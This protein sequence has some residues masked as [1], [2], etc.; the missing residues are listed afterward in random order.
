MPIDIGQPRKVST[1]YTG[2]IGAPPAPTAA[3][4]ASGAA[5]AGSAKQ[6]RDL[7]S[8]E[9]RAGQ[10]RR[11]FGR[12]ASPTFTPPSGAMPSGGGGTGVATTEVE[13]EA[14]WM[15]KWLG[16]AVAAA[17]VLSQTRKKRR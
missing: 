2:R 16:A 4:S 9:S 17:L 14:W 13:A 3:M 8:A 7:A 5:Y 11:K 12:M 1:K 15:N 6:R 10:R